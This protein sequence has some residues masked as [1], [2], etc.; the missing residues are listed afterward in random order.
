MSGEIDYNKLI[1]HFKTL[2]ITPINLLKFK[3]SF[4]IFKEIRDGDQTLQGIK[5]DKK[6]LNQI[7]VK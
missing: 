1:N 4:S 7:Q 6:K 2:G 5:E 3:G